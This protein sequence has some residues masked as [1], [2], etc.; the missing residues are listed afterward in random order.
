MTDARRLLN[1]LALYARCRG[2]G[3]VSRER[4]SRHS[5]WGPV[6]TIC[7]PRI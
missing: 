7:P 4:M 3:W 1:R 5:C 6:A 2:R